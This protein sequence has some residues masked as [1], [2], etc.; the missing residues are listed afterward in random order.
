MCRDIVVPTGD[1]RT[2]D[3]GV[4]ETGYDAACVCIVERIDRPRTINCFSGGAN[5]IH[6]ALYADK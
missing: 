1:G 2:R 3:G 4:G 6:L 5:R